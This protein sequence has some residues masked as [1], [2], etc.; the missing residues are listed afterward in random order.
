VK[1]IEDATTI[2]HLTTLFERPLRTLFSTNQML[3]KLLCFL[4]TAFIT[5]PFD[6]TLVCL[7]RLENDAI[8]GNAP[9]SACLE[10]VAEDTLPLRISESV[11]VIRERMRP[12]VEGQGPQTTEVTF[13]VPLVVCTTR[14]GLHGW[15][16]LTQVI[17]SV[18]P[19][20]PLSCE[21]W[22]A[23]MPSDLVTQAL[24]LLAGIGQPDNV[25]HIEGDR[26]KLRTRLLLNTD[27]TK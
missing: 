10:I 16:P 14:D 5:T 7:L 9:F 22:S 17:K 18:Q 3:P 24:T 12:F 25:L 23:V 26:N 20:K 2:Q 11:Q 27:D 13:H 1:H 21:C 4:E 6:R 15:T 19:G 8:D